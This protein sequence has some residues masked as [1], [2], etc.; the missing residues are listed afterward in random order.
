MNVLAI[1]I[2]WNRPKLLGRSIHSFLQ[3]TNRDARLFVLDDAGQ[4]QSEEHERWTL[5]STA[6]RYPTMGDKRNALIKM[7][8]KQYPQLNAVILW[9]DDD[10][11][12]SHTMQSVSDALDR[13]CWA[14][15]REALEMNE[16]GNSLRRV[17]TSSD[18]PKHN[19]DKS[20]CYGGCWAWRLDTFIALGMFPSTD[21]S[22][23]LKVAFPC[24]DKHGPS[25]DSSQGNPWYYYNRTNNS[26]SA[27]GKNFY[28]ERG[29]Q[30]I[31]P[32]KELSI[33]WNGPNIFDLPIEEGIHPR[34]W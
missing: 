28:R 19:F 12:F 23:D 7:A 2:T 18:N 11:Y 29:R 3:Q 9:D 14:Q 26:I 34:P 32:V 24:L 1:C 16:A 5:F 15:P 27:E 20:L 22:E 21:H 30:V 10:V 13:K 6:K 8:L 17:R 4:Y 25:A 31:E 33:G